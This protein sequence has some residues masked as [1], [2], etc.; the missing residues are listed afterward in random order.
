MILSVTFET[1]LRMYAEIRKCLIRQLLTK[2]SERLVHSGTFVCMLSVLYERFQDFINNVMKHDCCDSVGE[3]WNDSRN[4]YWRYFNDDS[5]SR[6]YLN[7]K[8]SLWI[9]YEC[10]LNL[11]KFWNFTNIRTTV[12][13]NIVKIRKLVKTCQKY[14]TW[15]RYEYIIRIVYNIL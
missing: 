13:E 2:I 12:H 5:C 15:V 14:I 1:I 11:V 10:C 9:Y 6:T 8:D 4:A 7:T 3:I